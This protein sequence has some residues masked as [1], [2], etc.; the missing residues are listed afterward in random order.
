MLEV[1]DDE[2]ED[3]V[4]KYLESCIQFIESALTNKKKVFVHCAAG[5]S[6]SPTI[7]I[8]Y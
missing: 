2:K 7:V 6:R 1:D 5:V 8:G 3:L 4:E